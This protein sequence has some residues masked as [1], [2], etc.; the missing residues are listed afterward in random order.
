MTLRLLE[1]IIKYF[2]ALIRINKLLSFVKLLIAEFEFL[3]TDEFYIN[4]VILLFYSGV[5][6][7]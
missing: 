4:T 2:I 1:Q 7:F 5:K 6:L 3:I